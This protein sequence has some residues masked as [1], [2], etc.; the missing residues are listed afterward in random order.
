MP[1]DEG[2]AVVPVLIDVPFSNHAREVIE[3]LATTPGVAVNVV[4]PAVPL[5]GDIVGCEVKD[6]AG[7]GVG[8][9]PASAAVSRISNCARMLAT[10]A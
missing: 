4:V 8:V 7:V 9:P 3:P 10:E 1:A 2:A 6:A 5:L